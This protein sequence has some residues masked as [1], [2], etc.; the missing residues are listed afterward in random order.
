MAMCRRNLFH[1]DLQ[2]CTELIVL[3]KTVSRLWFYAYKN[4]KIGNC[5][6]C[7]VLQRHIR[8]SMTQNGSDISVWEYSR[9]ITKNSNF[10]HHFLENG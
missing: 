6:R 10:K 3:S 2:V 1:Y 9:K 4:Y 5:A 8:P 7:T